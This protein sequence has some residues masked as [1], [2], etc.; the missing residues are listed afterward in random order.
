MGTGVVLESFSSNIGKPTKTTLD[1]IGFDYPSDKTLQTRFNISTSFENNTISGFKSI[2]I[3][4]LGK[5]YI[6][7]P[8][9]VVLDGVTK[10]QITDIDLR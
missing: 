4:S 3:T 9:L 5:G 6:Q 2:G 10:K 8:S 7:N 1:N